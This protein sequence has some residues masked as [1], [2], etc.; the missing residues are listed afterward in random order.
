MKKILLRITSIYFAIIFVISLF[1]GESCLTA[2][3]PSAVYAAEGAP[4][5]A[6]ASGKQVD[7]LFLHDTHSHLDSFL[8]MEDEEIKLA[9]GF[10]YIKTLINEKKADNPHT[11]ILD[12]GDFSMGTLVQTI[13]HSDAPELR[14]L[15]A[16]GCDVTT[17]G[18]HE[19]DY[20]S[21]GLADSLSAAA[22][23]GDPVPA[24]ALCN[25]DWETMETEGLTEEQALLKKAFDNY[26]M[27]DYVIIRKG[28]VKIAV[29][30]IFGEDSLS[31]APTCVLKFKNASEAAAETVA[32]IKE[33][34]NADL[35]DRK[36]VV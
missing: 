33:T 26:G 18:N 5:T 14:M 17:L 27:K 35:I 10:A 1:T 19:F 8:T 28:D 36:S 25:I 22:A 2:G 4:Q 24:L 23:S 15:G 29:L 30:G 7:V 12:G 9:G 3:I 11:L 16:L 34:E 31:C 6:D 13:F 21:Q 20:R 32:K